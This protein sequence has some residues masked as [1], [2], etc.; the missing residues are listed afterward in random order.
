MAFRRIQNSVDR[1]LDDRDNKQWSLDEID[2]AVDATTEDEKHWIKV[3][4]GWIRTF[5]LTLDSVVEKIVGDIQEKYPAIPL[6]WAFSYAMFRIS[7]FMRNAFVVEEDVKLWEVKS[8]NEMRE[9]Y[10]LRLEHW[11]RASTTRT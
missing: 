11:K 7:V 10:E 8:M 9:F 1:V 6:S 5:D 3:A 4:D 2:R